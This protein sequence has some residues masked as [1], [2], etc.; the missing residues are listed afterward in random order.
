MS[1]RR[2]TYMDDFF[3]PVVSDTAADLLPRVLAAQVV[4][5]I[6]GEHGLQLNMVANKTEVVVDF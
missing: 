2:S 6:A 4:I 1:L 3:L 5:E